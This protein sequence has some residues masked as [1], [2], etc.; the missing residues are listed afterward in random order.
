MLKISML[1]MS[2]KITNPRLKLH[3]PGAYRLILV[4]DVIYYGYN[5]EML[6]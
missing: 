5:F 2:L 6:T 3:H 1:D 4:Y